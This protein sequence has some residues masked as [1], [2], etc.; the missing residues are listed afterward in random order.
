MS[1]K[2]RIA[3][4]GA[5]AI[6]VAHA[7]AVTRAEGVALAAVVDRSASGPEVAARH[8]AKHFSYLDEMLAAGGVDGAILALPSAAHAEAA[9]ACIRAGIPPLVE[10]PFVTDI[11]EGEAVLAA[12]ERAGIPVLTGHHRR[13]NPLIGKALEIVRS[14]RLGEVTSVQAQ[15]WFFKPE[16]YFEPDWRRRPGAGPVY[17]NLIHDVDLM[18]A[19][20]G[21]IAAVQAMEAGALRGHDVEE[22]AVVILRFAS[23]ALGTLNVSDAASSP[24][25]WE[26]TARENPHYPATD[27]NCYW[28][29]GAKG[30]LALP[31]LALWSHDG[32]D[33]WWSPIS[34][35]RPVHDFAD[36]LVV[37]A[38]HFGA[39]I[40][41]EAE[42]AVSG[43]DGLAAVRAIEAIKRAARTET[44]VR[45]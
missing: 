33:G 41:G 27:Q 11:A 25:S 45:L 19:F 29:G 15:T 23:G 9:L 24:W 20:C 40:R 28:I 42:P 32:P 16:S 13:Y 5:G 43:G 6:G 35:M 2:T 31:N 34:A 21:P 14:G 1:A 17:T 38:A 36:P 12:A 26:L 37:Q 7:A 10:K 22:T 44:I 3:V 4:V 8:G 39:A 18:Q 30:S